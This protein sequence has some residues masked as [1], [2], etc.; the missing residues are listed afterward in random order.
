MK[1]SLFFYVSTACG[2]IVF[3]CLFLAAMRF[4]DYKIDEYYGFDRVQVVYC[5]EGE[6]LTDS[7]LDILAKVPAKFKMQEISREELFGR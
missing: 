4:V 1:K 5:C 7:E 3:S 2:V 6:D